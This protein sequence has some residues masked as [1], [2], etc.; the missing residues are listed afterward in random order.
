MS[1]IIMAERTKIWIADKMKELMKTK[2][3]DKI[4]ATEFGGYGCADDV[5]VYAAEYEGG[6]F[7][8]MAL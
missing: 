1:V 5:C 2:P 3:L 8:S 4:S 7:L 6:L